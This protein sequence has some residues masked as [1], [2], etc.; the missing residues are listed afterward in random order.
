MIEQV[1]GLIAAAVEK[2]GYPAV[3]FDVS[4]PPRKEFGDLT[5]N[6][7]FQLSKRAKKAPQKIA[8]ELIERISTHPDS[9][10]LSAEPHPAGYINFRANF[11]KLSTSTLKQLLQDP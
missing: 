11:A 6:V 5:C 4:E 2:A 7:A 1:R 3:D 8:G 9:F 10:V